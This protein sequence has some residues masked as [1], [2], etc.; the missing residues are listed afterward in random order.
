MAQFRITSPD[1]AIYNVT[2]PEGATEQDALAQVQAQHA[3]QPTQA[4]GADTMRDSMARGLPPLTRPNWLG[5]EM[6]A[7]PPARPLG[8]Q[9]QDV[10]D[11]AGGMATGIPAGVA[12]IPGD[13]EALGRFGLNKA[14]AD[15][16]PKTTLPTSSEMGDIV[17]G[18]PPANEMVAQGRTGGNLLSPLAWMK[19]TKAVPKV[20]GPVAAHTLGL[21]TGAGAAA[22]QEGFKAVKEGGQAS[23]A[24]FQ[25]MR[26]TGG[27]V[28]GDVVETAKDA[29]ETMRQEKNAAYQAG[30]GS[31]IKGD[32]TVLDFAPIDAAIRNVSGVGVFKGKTL[33]KGADKVW[34]AIEDTVDDWRQS[35]PATFHT[36]EGLDALK[37]KIGNL[38]YEED[39]KAVAGPHTPGSVIVNGVYNAIKNQIVQQAPGYARVMRD[40]ME[41]SDELRNV[42][43]TFSLGRNATTDASLRKLQSILRNNANTNY[44]ARV[45]MGQK[46]ASQ[47]GAETLMPAL[48]GQMLSSVAPRGI[49]GGVAGLGGLTSYGF[50]GLP[51]AIPY[52][53]ASSPRLVGEGVGVAGRLARL[54]NPNKVAG[55]AGASAGVP[56][57][58]GEDARLLGAMMTPQ[59][60]ARLLAENQTA[61]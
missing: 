16:S 10:T 8:Q 37:K 19:T 61:P 26:K 21:T 60:L 45:E 43:S 56:R 41:A 52:A 7:S 51:A 18:G 58:A 38:A 32:P 47:P 40:Y 9:M 28:S 20:A 36:P 33:S 2:A 55:A 5:Q 31:T 25:N 12:G 6:P 44:G 23:D 35:D 3:P 53:A 57:I 39:L 30:I 4:G 49:Q 48:S 15:V 22:I 34:K 50:G 54:L 24:F 42:E 14:G 29:V 17:A 27:V 59:I 1:G 46:L 13:V 11:L